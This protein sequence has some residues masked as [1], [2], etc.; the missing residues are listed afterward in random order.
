MVPGLQRDLVGWERARMSFIALIIKNLVRQR[1]I[2]AL[3]RPDVGTIAIG[4]PI[5][6]LGTLAMIV[7]HRSAQ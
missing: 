7:F 4:L 5:A 3:D 1:V 2:A 6:A